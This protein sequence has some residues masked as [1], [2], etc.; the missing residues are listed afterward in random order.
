MN[1]KNIKDSVLVLILHILIYIF[2]PNSDDSVILELQSSGRQNVLRLRYRHRVRRKGD[3]SDQIDRDQS[4]RSDHLSE[5]SS[6]SPSFFMAVESI[7]VRLADD[8]WHRVALT[9]SG[10]QLQVFLDCKYVELLISNCEQSSPD[11]MTLLGTSKTHNK[12]I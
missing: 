3:R 6:S 8:E 11:K 5:G 1:L 2:S 4:D 12:Q 9:I 7:P 10:N